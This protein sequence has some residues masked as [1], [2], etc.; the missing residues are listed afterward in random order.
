MGRGF[1]VT[2]FVLG[3]GSQD[4]ADLQQTCQTIAQDA[5]EALTG[6]ASAAGHAGLRAALNGAVTSRCNPAYSAM[7]AALGHTS[8]GLASSAEAYMAAEQ[9]VTGQASAVGRSIF[10]NDGFRA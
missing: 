2:P 4:I 3:T 8:Q 5:E 9:K 10:I 6:M 7:W 1:T